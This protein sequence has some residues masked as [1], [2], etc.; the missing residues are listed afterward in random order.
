MKRDRERARE[1]CTCK[2]NYLVTRYIKLNGIVIIFIADREQL[3]SID[4]FDGSTFRSGPTVPFLPG[5]CAVKVDDSTVFLAGGWDAD[6]DGPTTK[7]FL[8]DVGT[9]NWR[10][11]EDMGTR[12]WYAGCN[13][14]GREVVVLGGWNGEK[15]GSSEIFDL[16]S[17]TWS[18]GPNL[19]ASLGGVHGFGSEMVAV[20]KE[21]TF[22][23]FGGDMERG[24]S[25]KIVGY[26]AAKREFFVHP[27][28][29]D[30]G[31][32]G[33]NMVKVPWSFNC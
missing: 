32:D 24:N 8:L 26:D 5:A 4:I 1:T 28:R 33:H 9:W 21:N 31:G 25:D 16:D 12:R 2:I 19:P 7:A 17:E 11:L 15:L 30:V 14:V 23:V 10:Q 27:K 20:A 18:R 22:Y 3:S 13:A 29:M 6:D